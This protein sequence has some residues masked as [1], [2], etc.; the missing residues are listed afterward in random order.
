M[1]PVTSITLAFTLAA[2][3]RLDA[4]LTLLPA[5]GV[6]N[7]WMAFGEAQLK[8]QRIQGSLGRTPNGAT[9]FHMACLRFYE[10]WQLLQESQNAADQLKSRLNSFRILKSR[11]KQTRNNQM[12]GPP[13]RYFKPGRPSMDEMELLDSFGQ[14][15]S[16]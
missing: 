3:S 7:S 4:E 11:L 2:T 1:C 14:S 12:P 5:P 8:W 16:G 6:V 10:I 9:D 13:L 15:K